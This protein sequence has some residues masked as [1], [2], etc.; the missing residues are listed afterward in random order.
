MTLA[1]DLPDRPLTLD[2]VTR[3]AEADTR[4]RFELS[5]GSLVVLP[6]VLQPQIL[7]PSA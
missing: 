1:A 5:Q 2:D 3:L 7:K 4:H 6:P